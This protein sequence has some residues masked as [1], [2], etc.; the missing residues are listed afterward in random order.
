[1]HA[2]GA[3]TDFAMS[4]LLLIAVLFMP[5]VQSAC[6]LSCSITNW[7]NACCNAACKSNATLIQSSTEAVIDTLFGVRSAVKKSGNALLIQWPGACSPAVPHLDGIITNGGKGVLPVGGRCHFFDAVTCGGT[8]SAPD[9]PPP[10]PPPSPPASLPPL[11]PQPSPPP[12]PPPLPQ[13]PPSPPLPPSPPSPPLPPSPSS[14]PTKS[15][16]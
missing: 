3:H 2:L 5:G 15:G 16:K 11:P 6:T 13:S 8:V 12:P 14:L 4:R 9:P 7:R 10:P 1:M